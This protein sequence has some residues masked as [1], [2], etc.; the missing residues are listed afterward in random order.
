MGVLKAAVMT[1]SLSDIFLKTNFFW[2]L[3]QILLP[4][5]LILV[6]LL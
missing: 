6:I 3:F 5:A 1:T 2:N 4:I